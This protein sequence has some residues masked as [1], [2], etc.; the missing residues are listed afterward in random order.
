MG[1][2]VPIAHFRKWYGFPPLCA[3]LLA[4]GYFKLA[5]DSR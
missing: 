1:F 4:S 2:H 5:T 3:H